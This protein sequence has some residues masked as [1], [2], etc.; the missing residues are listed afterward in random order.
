MVFK[1]RPIKPLR[2]IYGGVP[3]SI[4]YEIRLYKN[5][6]N[7]QDRRLAPVEEEI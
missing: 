2:A 7:S 1:G 3:D 5:F 6:A 4:S